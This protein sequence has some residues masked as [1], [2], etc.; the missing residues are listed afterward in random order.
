[1]TEIRPVGTTLIDA[2]GQTDR[3]DKA[4]RRLK[5]AQRIYPYYL[6]SADLGDSFLLRSLLENRI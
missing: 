1:M 2:D 4:D 5:K 6:L 3:H